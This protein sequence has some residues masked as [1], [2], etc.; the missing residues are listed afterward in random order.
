[1]GGKTTTT[2]VEIPEPTLEE[3]KMA[4][5]FSALL[6]AQMARD[7][8]K[9]EVFKRQAEIDAIDAQL[10]DPNL[11]IRTAQTL[12]EE[13][14]RLMNEGYDI[15]YQE[16]PEVAARRKKNEA[17]IQKINEQFFDVTKKVLRGDFS[18]TPEQR[19]T[20]KNLTSE[21]FDP[22]MDV[23]TAEFS[24][25]QQDVQNAVDRLMESGRA[26]L[27][28]QLEEQNTNLKRQSQ[29][30]GR[31]TADKR[32]QEV[33]AETNQ[34]AIE[35]LYRSGQA[36]AAQAQGQLSGQRALAL[37]GVAENKGL[38]GY[39]LALQAANPLQSFGVGQQ[40]SQLQGALGAQNI[41]NQFQSV[42]AL[43]NR[44]GQMGNIRAAQPTQTTTE[45]FGIF[46][47]LGGLTDLAGA[48]LSGASTFGLI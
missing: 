28:N 22:I 33:L 35:R 7:Y 16:R 4:E 6:D 47:I 37:G 10:A 21:F 14:E 5:Q 27:Q 18:T 2:Q 12:Q 3:R 41:A 44:L 29:L 23:V 24:T 8:E 19:E 9:T 26:D 36:A 43:T 38:A 13:K 39:N 17:E 48:G 40:F 30:L 34:G 45:P 15:T 1:M 20:I 32:I 42:N 46:D 25:A 31:S 11:D